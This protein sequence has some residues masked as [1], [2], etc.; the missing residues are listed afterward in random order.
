MAK[1]KWPYHLYRLHFAS[2]LL[3]KGGTQLISLTSLPF[4]LKGGSAVFLIL[5]QNI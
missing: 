5:A 2:P 4:L 1:G 3:L